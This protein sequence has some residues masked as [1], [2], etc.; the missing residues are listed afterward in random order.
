MTSG[1]LPLSIGQRAMWLLHRLEPGSSAYHVVLAVRLRGAVDVPGLRTAVTAVTTRHGELTAT[2]TEVDGEP[3]K[4]AGGTPPELLDVRDVH[5]HDESGLRSLLREV[6]TATVDLTR[7]PVFRVVLLRRTADDAVLV[8]VAHHIVCDA[9]SLWIVARDL[10]AAYEAVRSGAD[11]A[12]ALPAP[13][14]TYDDVVAAEDRRLAERPDLAAHW[15]AVCA[16]A[17]VA[18][19]GPAGT[20]D[21]A[22]TADPAGDVC[23]LGFDPATARALHTVA[24]R[25]SVTPAALL[26]GVFQA[27]VHRYTAQR[28]FLIACAG[29]TRT[30]RALRDVVGCLSNTLVLRSAFDP[31]TTFADAARS[32]GTALAAAM[33]HAEYPYAWLSGAARAAGVTEPACRIGLTLLRTDLIEPPLPMVPDGALEG[34]E[35]VHRGLRMALLDVPQMEGQFDLAL[36][37]RFGRTELSLALKY[38]QRVLDRPFVQRFGRALRAF[39]TAALQDPHRRV[40][41][42]SLVDRDETDRLLALGRGARSV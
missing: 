12:A 18:R 2:F 19:L 26:T 17:D 10:F 30:R 29:T 24:R 39:V 25:L 33:A 21:P 13:G 8:L 5:W 7:D 6:G 35:I 1:T 14:T 4:T 32:A 27:L 15:L 34:A 16:G 38:D 28:D 20:S 22:A 42:S 36:E 40:A 23:Q 3:R 9:T 31:T 37:A 41:A 11:P